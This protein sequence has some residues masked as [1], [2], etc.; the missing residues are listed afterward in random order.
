MD[1]K[2]AAT[3]EA[4]NAKIDTILA[5]NVLMDNNYKS[6]LNQI[7]ELNQQ[8]NNIYSLVVQQAKP[9]PPL[10]GGTVTA[11]ESA[12]ALPLQLSTKKSA[13]SSPVPS[14]VKKP[15]QEMVRKYPVEQKILYQD[16]KK[17]AMA[18]F[19]ITGPATK[20]EGKTNM[21]GKWNANLAPGQYDVTVVKY[22]TDE[23]PAI[24]LAYKIDIVA[25]G[26]VELPERKAID[27]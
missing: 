16:G 14:V 24:N 12:T 17:V 5:F 9:P 6:S 1:E 10:S 13:Q 23:K 3:I 8:L 4:L 7:K 21:L 27:G 2:L 25:G 18:S 15:K 26:P 22:G 19:T 20:I 11:V